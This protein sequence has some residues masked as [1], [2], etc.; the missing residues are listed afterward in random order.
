[1]RVPIQTLFGYLQASSSLDAVAKEGLF[2]HVHVARRI[3]APPF[4][5]GAARA[6][7]TLYRE[8]FVSPGCLML[9]GICLN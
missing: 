8:G 3:G 2:A 9:L 5:S 6:N 7:H 1:M 4:S